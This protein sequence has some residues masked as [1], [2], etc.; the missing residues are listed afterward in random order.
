MTDPAQELQAQEA[1]VQPGHGG[2]GLSGVGCY[3]R[4]G[5]RYVLGVP[6]ARSRSAAAKTWATVLSELSGVPVVLEWESP[7]WHARWVDGPTQALLQERAA[8]LDGYG[9]GGPLPARLITFS[10][11]VS[12][13]ARAVGWLV[14]GSQVTE[15]ERHRGMTAELV[16]DNWC[17]DTSY[18]QQRAGQDVWAAAGVLAAVSRQDPGA[19]AAL[20]TSAVPPLG[21]AQASGRVI[22]DLPGRVVSY[23][24][25]GRGGPPPHLLQPPPDTRTAEGRTPPAAPPPDAGPSTTALVCRRCGH[26]L[27]TQSIRG[28]RPAQYCSDRCR[29]AAHRNRTRASPAH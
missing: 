26:P 1:R 16:V 7:L 19:M 11:R 14:H 13:V 10:R 22:V 5:F 3:D 29:V 2:P 8:V 6:V 15:S 21:A 4:L 27:P 28:G 25:P 23:R 9:V 20:M 18:P 12:P 17:T 24:W